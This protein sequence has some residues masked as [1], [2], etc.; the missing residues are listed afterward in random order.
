M[1]ET[2]AQR[3]RAVNAS[4]RRAR[5]VYRKAD[6]AGEILER[7]LDRLIL[8]KTIVTPESMISM[9]TKHLAYVQRV[10]D[11]DGALSDAIRLA[12]SYTR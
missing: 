2:F 12:N 3:T 9:A 8:R 10:N 6:T 11:M 1:A 7:E 4:L 5:A